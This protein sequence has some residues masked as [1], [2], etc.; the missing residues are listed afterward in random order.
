MKIEKIIT[1]TQA[2]GINVTEITLLSIEEA[3]EVNENTRCIHNNWWLRS[4]GNDTKYAAYITCDGDVYEDGFNVDYSHFGVRPALKIRN[5][6]SKLNIGDAIIF[7][8]KKWTVINDTTVLCDS[9]IGES[10]FRNDWGATDANDYEASD[11]KKFL[12]AWKENEC[13]KEK[14][15]A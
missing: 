5:M 3:K 14:N 7:A 12:E 10:C 4:P 2:V 13:R 6:N 15:Y 11:I 1:T 8:E 9:I